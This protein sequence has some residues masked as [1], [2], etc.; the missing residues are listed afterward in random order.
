MPDRLIR[1]SIC[2]SE[3]LNQL[4]DFEERFWHRLIVNCDDYGRFDARPEILKA[5]L[6]P[7]MEGK[8]KKDMTGTLSKLAS[9]GLVELYDVDGKPFL[10][11]VTWDKYQR[12]R[13]KRSKF[14]EPVGA[15]CQM[16]A[17]DG[18]SRRNPIQSESNPDAKAESDARTR[19]DVA[20]VMN[21]FLNRIDPT[22]SRDCLDQ[23]MGYVDEMG[24]ECCL[25]AIQI[26]EDNNAR[27]WSYIRS[28]LRDK[29]AQGVRNLAQWD[30]LE[31]KRQQAASIMRGRKQ[32]AAAAQAPS[33]WA[34]EAVAQMMGTQ[35][36]D[37]NG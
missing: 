21:A 15:C 18:N 37:T 27:K 11:V 5:R 9:V 10:R 16:T 4:N 1:E 29:C 12:V 30:A 31:A 3:T 7:L 26:A 32:A 17:Y 19:E 22:P 14:P 2:T 8:T 36:E 25:R 23:L 20:A 35:E 24:A 6:F 13:A 33:E 28:V 34:R